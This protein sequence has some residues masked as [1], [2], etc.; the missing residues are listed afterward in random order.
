L[1]EHHACWYR[2]CQASIE[3]LLKTTGADDVGKALSVG[4]LAPFGEG[5]SVNPKLSRFSKSDAASNS[6]HR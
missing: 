1:R 4:E 5:Q 2:D 3:A 6:A